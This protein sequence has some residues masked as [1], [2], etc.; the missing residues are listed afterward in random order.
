[1]SELTAGLLYLSRDATI[2]MAA[3]AAHADFVDGHQAIGKRWRIAALGAPAHRMLGLPD[4]RVTLLD[5]AQSAEFTRHIDA[6][7]AASHAAPI[8]YFYQAGEQGWGYQ[9]YHQGQRLARADI[10]YAADD[11]IAESMLRAQYPDQDIHAAALLGQEAWQT[12]M[13]T[14]RRG[15]KFSARVNRDLVLA[16]PEVFACFGL[17]TLML[18]KL[19]ALL[20]PAAVLAAYR[21]GTRFTLV[22]KFRQL[23]RL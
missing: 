23:I 3:L 11:R 6:L 22:D 16:N 21:N 20:E 8:L 1:M 19:S 9:L 4:H 13:D 5:Q 10:D 2:V 12:T 14:V 17:T 15:A 18:K 7:E